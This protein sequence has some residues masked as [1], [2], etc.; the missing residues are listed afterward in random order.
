VERAYQS[1]S[2][3]QIAPALI[4]AQGEITAAIKENTNPAFK[5]RYADLNSVIDAAKPALQKHDIFVSQ[6]P[7]HVPVGGDGHLAVIR[8]VLLH[9]SG[10]FVASELPLKVDLAKAQEVGSWITY[11]RRYSLAAILSI[12]QEDDDGEAVRRGAEE[13]AR[14]GT[15]PTGAP[16]RPEAPAPDKATGGWKSTPT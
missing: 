16:P 1:D 12:P 3:D 2:F 14:A 6:Q 13:R 5:S 10:Q 8:T 4:A 9:K 7:W 15:F 11:A